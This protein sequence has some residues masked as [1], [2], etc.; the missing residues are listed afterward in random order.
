[1]LAFAI[2]R[3]GQSLFVLVVMSFLV[4][5]GVFAVGNPV[6][7]L[8]NPQADAE[9]RGAREERDDLDRV[10]GAAHRLLAL[11]NDVLDLSKIEAGAMSP[12]ADAVDVDGLINEVVATVR[13]AATAN[14]STITVENAALGR[15]DTD[16]FKLSQCLLNLMANAAKFTM[17]GQIKL[18]ARRSGLAGGD[19]LEFHVIDT[20]IGISAEAQTRLFQPFVSA[21]KATGLG[22]GLALAR[23]TVVD[24]GG[25]MW[26]DSNGHGACFS[27]RLPLDGTNGPRSDN[28][29]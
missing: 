25:D 18:C 5:I 19:W 10:H 4:F 11:I 21:G 20:G 13:P 7:L 1:M 16:G 15:A 9:E 29:M 27:F 8:V 17:D 22:L 26:A 14:G 6:E 3:F 24:H 23:Q 2:R 28:R 12:T